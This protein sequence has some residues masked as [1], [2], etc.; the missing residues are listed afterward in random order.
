MVVI[1]SV[2]KFMNMT[3]NLYEKALIDFTRLLIFFVISFDLTE[4]NI[5]IAKVVLLKIGISGSI[6]LSFSFKTHDNVRLRLCSICF[7]TLL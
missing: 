7:C 5:Y 2:Q 6:K 4:A 1:L 3:K